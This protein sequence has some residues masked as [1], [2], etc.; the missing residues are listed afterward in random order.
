VYRS[1]PSS[2]VVSRSVILVACLTTFSL[3]NSTDLEGYLMKFQL[4]NTELDRVVE[5]IYLY[6]L[7]SVLLT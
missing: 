5:Y 6:L 7:P 1:E 4:H 2:L 3:Q